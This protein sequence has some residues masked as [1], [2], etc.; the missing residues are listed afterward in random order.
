MSGVEIAGLRDEWTRETKT[1][2]RYLGEAFYLGRLREK[3]P[4]PPEKG[5]SERKKNLEG[6]MY[7]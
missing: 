4:V 1:D 7:S 6:S 3:K 5:C 2:D